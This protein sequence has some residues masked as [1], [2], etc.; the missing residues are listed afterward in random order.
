MREELRYNLQNM[1]DVLFDKV[2]SVS[3]KMKGSPRGISLTYKIGD[4]KKEKDKLINRIGKRVAGIR[5]GNPEFG[6]DK[7]LN[8]FFSRLDDIQQQIDDAIAERKRRLYPGKK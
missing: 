1:G 8:L 7:K 6:S 5:K 3:D 2:S 4:L